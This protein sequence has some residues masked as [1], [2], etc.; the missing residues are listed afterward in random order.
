MKD[1]NKVFEKDFK[2][3]MSLKQYMTINRRKGLPFSVQEIPTP[4]GYNIDPDLKLKEVAV[5]G[6]TEPFFDKLNGT[7]LTQLDKTTFQKPYYNSDGTVYERNGE[8]K[9][10]DIDVKS[11][12]I[13]V[14]SPTNIG[15]KSEIEFRGKMRPHKP[16]VGFE[17]INYRVVNG[18][19][20]YTYIIPKENI[21]KL[22]FCALV[23]SA[24]LVDR[25][26]GYKI[27]FTNGYFLNLLVIPYS[28]AKKN[29]NIKVLAIKNSVD[30]KEEIEKLT[31]YWV[32][33]G[34]IF[35]PYLTEVDVSD[36]GF[37]AGKKNIGMQVIEGNKSKDSFVRIK[38]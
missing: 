6:L 13:A 23:L 37:S 34:I 18:K 31:T 10:R 38:V 25:Y 21:V 7:K 11:G 14:E 36:Y 30:F 22:N 8:K 26:F 32:T 9:Y 4:E 35:H 12:F 19:K 27:A 17:Y 5:K 29:N 15:L 2:K 28:N 20:L 16:T 3:M 33:K 1:I 24:T